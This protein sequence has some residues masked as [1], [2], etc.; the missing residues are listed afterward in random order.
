MYGIMSSK[1][2]GIK[3]LAASMKQVEVE[4]MNL[5]GGHDDMEAGNNVDCDP[6]IMSRMLMDLLLDSN[7]GGEGSLGAPDLELVFSEFDSDDYL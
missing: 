2:A 1:V 7:A 3:E 5:A 4:I 6:T